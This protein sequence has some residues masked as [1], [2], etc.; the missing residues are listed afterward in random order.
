MNVKVLGA[1]GISGLLMAGGVV[2]ASASF[3]IWL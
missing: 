3:N 2:S 1:I